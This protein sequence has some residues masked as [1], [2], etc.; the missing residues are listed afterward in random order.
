MDTRTEKN[1][2]RDE[3]LRRILH[4]AVALSWPGIDQVYLAPFAGVCCRQCG[5]DRAR[6]GT[7]GWCGATGFQRH[8]ERGGA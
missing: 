8:D 1:V 3:T 7:C 2:T 4:F 5:Y 6:Y